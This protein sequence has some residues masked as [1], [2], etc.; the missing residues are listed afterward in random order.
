MYS[1]ESKNGDF[2][3]E[4]TKIKFKNEDLFFDES[5]LIK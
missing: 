4:G 3:K 1:P 5:S 2:I